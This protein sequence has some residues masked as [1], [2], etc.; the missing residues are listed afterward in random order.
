MRRLKHIALRYLTAAFA[1]FVL[2][3]QI[4]SGVVCV[5]NDGHIDIESGFEACCSPATS[6]HAA[7][8]GAA[9]HGVD[10][11]CGPCMDVLIRAPQHLTKEV[12]NFGLTAAPFASLSVEPTGTKARIVEAVSSDQNWRSLVPLS[13]VILLT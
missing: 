11:E 13:S 5:G 2:T 8:D 9:L 12:R 3:A 1:V 6:G 4:G 10:S 7:A